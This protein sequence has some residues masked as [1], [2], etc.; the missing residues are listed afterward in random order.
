M[1][2]W[3]FDSINGSDSNNGTSSNTPKQSF[4]AFNGYTPAPGDTVLFRRG[5]TQ[6]ITTAYKGVRSGA[7]DTVRNRYGAYGE[8]QVP[9]S[10]WKYGAASGNMILNCAQQKYSDF[11]DMYFDMRG[12]NC[13]NGLYFASQGTAESVGNRIVR[14]FFQGSNNP[15]ARNGSGLNIIQEATSTVYPRDFTIENCEFFDN[16]GHGLAIIGSRNITVR[17]CKSYR[18]GQYDPDGGHGF[19]ARY[20]RTD[21]A[22]GWTNTGGT[23]WQRTLAAAELDVYYIQTSVNPYFRVKRTTG[24]ATAPGIGEYGVSGGILY[25]NLNSF[26]NPSTQAIR[27]AW[28]RCC[29]LIIEDCESYENYWNRLAPYHE[30]HGFAFD[31]FSDESIFRRNK[32]FNNQGAGFSIN[33]GDRNQLI[34]NLAYGNWQA[35]VVC[36]P[37]DGTTIVNNTFL[38]NNAG[39]GRHDAEIKFGGYCKDAVASNNILVSTVAYGIARET[40]DTGFSGVTNAISGH[41]T[42]PEKNAAVSRTIF[43]APKLDER[44][45]RPTAPELI[46]AGTYLGH[47]DFNGKQFYN[48]PNIGAVDDLS[49]TSARYAFVRTRK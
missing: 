11:E 12:T 35:G 48:P 30:G 42:A 10:I 47:K 6:I 24:T 46:R 39:T 16:E 49:A 32:S 3:Y 41:T 25:I 15:A 40:T 34:G 21:A 38:R 18:N 29:G 37:S 19:T 8:A 31:D 9:Y 27:Y 36:N 22:S 23:I 45:Y 43:A 5:T 4:S 2:I 17:R 1:T 33:R 44:L 13:R 26:S 28:G 20:N 14:C 7:S